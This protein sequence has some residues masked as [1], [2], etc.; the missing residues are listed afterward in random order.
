MLP[1]I[2]K[3]ILEN[4][5]PEDLDIVIKKVDYQASNPKLD[6]QVSV[7]GYHEQ[8]NFVQRWNIE[9]IQYRQSKFSLDYSSSLEISND[10]PI[11]WQ[12]SDY[13]SS[14]YFSGNCSDPNLMFIDLYK[15]HK[16]LFE[17]LISFEETLNQGNDFCNFISN[18]TSGLLAN[19]PKK[20]LVKYG[21]ILKKYNLN[22]TI[23]GDRIPT[24]WNGEKHE[25]EVGNA[26]V[27]FIDS[28]Y[29]VAD[30]FLF[31]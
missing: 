30:E 8:D 25:T 5:D 27:L 3:D 26:K 13:Q 16:S 31:S 19:G 14:I 6:I 23:I 21:E 15:L 17:G 11:L 28:S 24:Y 22:Y 2:L 1:K 29:I 10:H 12:F 7:H 18:S 9:T 20:L 4:Y